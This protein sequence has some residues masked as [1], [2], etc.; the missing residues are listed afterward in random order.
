MSKLPSGSHRGQPK[1]DRDH[2]RP[3]TSPGPTS[4]EVEARLAEVVGPATYAVAEQY[5]RYGLR[6]R[7]LT[8][9]VMVALLV[10]LIWRQVPS[11]Q[12]LARLLA[13]DTVLW[14]PPRRVSQQALSQRLRCLPAELVGAVL[15][16]MLP[17]LAERAATRGRPHPPAV[18]RAQAR[19]GRVW[20]VDGTTLE[21]VFRK[22]GLLREGAGA[23]LASSGGKCV[24]VLDLVSHLP[25]QIWVGDAPTANDRRWLPALRELLGDAPANG[26]ETPVAPGDRGLLV[27]DAGYYAFAFFD[28]LT[29]QGVGFLTRAKVD[30]AFEVERVLVSSPTVRDRIIRLGQYRSTP[31]RHLARL[32]EVRV[33][34]AWRA[35]LTNLLD[36]AALA[37]PDVVDLYSRRWGVETAFL[38]V[39][40]LLGL[41][42]LWTGAYNGI[43]MQVWATWMLYATL[44][45]L[46]DAVADTLGVP[47]ERVSLEM[48]FRGLYFF[49]LAA[50]RREADDPVAYL[51]SQ[52]DLG[53]LKATR[54]KRA[55]ERLDALPQE[56]KL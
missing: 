34:T 50:A 51:A 18:A 52:P 36:P 8:L 39:K 25:V 7:V 37:I 24:A 12:G 2:V 22:V 1:W 28:W 33:G 41:S 16:E 47:L 31:C 53:I 56:L 9:P 17:A 27:L 19:F 54:P 46:A 20:V 49:C 6:W 55:R 10:A 15:H 11:V 38:L 35:Y 45:D 14:E 5:R 44:V 40:R 21:H 30:A 32:V 42:Y 3:R 4:E 26:S 23:G 13:R 29:E 48:V 43:E